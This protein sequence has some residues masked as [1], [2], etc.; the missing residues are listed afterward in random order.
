MNHHIVTWAVEIYGADTPE[1]AAQQAYNIQSNPA[2]KVTSFAVQDME[3]KGVKYVDVSISDTGVIGVEEAREDFAVKDQAANATTSETQEPELMG[4]E[5]A[6][7]DL[8]EDEKLHLIRCEIG[9]FDVNDDPRNPFETV[10]VVVAVQ[11]IKEALDKAVKLVES[12]I[13]VLRGVI[14]MSVA[15]PVEIS[16]SEL[17]I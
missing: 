7:E 16:H 2:K 11:H 8:E 17:G 12:E 9:L 15:E 4:V 6:R 13:A 1:E 5:E 3:T 10:A 14:F